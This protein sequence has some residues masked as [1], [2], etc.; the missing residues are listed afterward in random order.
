[1][2]DTPT[3]FIFPKLTIRSRDLQTDDAASKAAEYVTQPIATIRVAWLAQFLQSDFVS[4][5]LA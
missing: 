1:M 3:T 5:S 2:R 4:Q